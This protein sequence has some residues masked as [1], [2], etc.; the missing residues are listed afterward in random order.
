MSSQ[1]QKRHVELRTSSL[2]GLVE[3]IVLDRSPDLE[4]NSV[5]HVKE[6]R[7]TAQIQQLLK[8]EQVR[9]MFRK[10][11]R[12]LKPVFQLGLSKIDV[13]DASAHTGQNGDPAH[14]KSW[15]GP[16]VSVAKPTAIAQVVKEIN[17]THVSIHA[18]ERS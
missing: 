15:K 2:E 17:G 10:I 16:W 5:A 13:P 12:S 4:Q 7:V 1:H 9:K 3:A 6:E 8:R 11:K 14:P 18:L